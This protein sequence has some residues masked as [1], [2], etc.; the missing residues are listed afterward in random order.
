MID[1]TTY[2]EWT[3]LNQVNRHRL[4]L[5]SEGKFQIGSEDVDT[6]DIESSETLQYAFAWS[7]RYL[8]KEPWGYQIAKDILKCHLETIHKD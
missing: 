1:P 8:R 3:L 6:Y 7:T 5:F 2:A 4:K